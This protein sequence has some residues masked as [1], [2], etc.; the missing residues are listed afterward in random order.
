MKEMMFF[1]SQKEVRKKKKEA[2]FSFPDDIN[3]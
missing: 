3:I 1:S 2:R